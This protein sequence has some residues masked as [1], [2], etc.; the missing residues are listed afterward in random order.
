MRRPRRGCWVISFHQTLFILISSL[1]ALSSLL[2]HLAWLSWYPLLAL[3]SLIHLLLREHFLSFSVIFFFNQ[4]LTPATVHSSG[5]LPPH[6]RQVLPHHASPYGDN[7]LHSMIDSFLWITTWFFP[8]HAASFH[9]WHWQAPRRAASVL[10]KYHMI[11]K[12][13]YL[14]GF[15][16][17]NGIDSDSMPVLHTY[18]YHTNTITITK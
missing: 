14:C 17:Y 10:R 5:F 3:S 16:L 1:L 8:S 15:I 12:K 4:P 18:I 9:Q 6:T 11:F 7:S 2:F 13:M